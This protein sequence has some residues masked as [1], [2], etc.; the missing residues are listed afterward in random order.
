MIAS[1]FGD[2]FSMSCA[3]DCGSFHNETSA[4]FTRQPPHALLTAAIA[5]LLLSFAHL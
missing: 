5:T 3:L 2:T 4:A 1:Q